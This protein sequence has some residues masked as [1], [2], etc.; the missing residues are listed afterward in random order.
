MRSRRGGMEPE[1]GLDDIFGEAFAAVPALA[2]V[3]LAVD[4]VPTGG[5][6]GAPSLPPGDF[7]AAFAGVP[8][9]ERQQPPAAPPPRRIVGSG[10]WQRTKLGLLFLRS[11][12]ERWQEQRRRQREG[13]AFDSLKRVWNSRIALRLGD[14]LISGPSGG[15]APTCHPNAWTLRGL[16]RVAFSG[17]GSKACGDGGGGVGVTTANAGL[18]RATSTCAGIFSV[19]QAQRVGAIV[20]KMKSREA[21]SIFLSSHYD[22]T[23]R[24]VRF[25]LLQQ[26]VQRHAR[27]LR[28]SA[29][30]KWELVSSERF[31]KLHANAAPRS[32]VVELFAQRMTVSCFLEDSQAWVRQDILCPPRMLQNSGASVVCKAVNAGVPSFSVDGIKDICKGAR[33]V[34]LAEFPDSASSNFRKLH[35]CAPRL[36]ENCLFVPGGCTA[37]LCTRVVEAMGADHPSLLGDV[38][39]AKFVSHLS[40]HYNSLCRALDGVLSEVRIVERR[41]VSDQD[42]ELWQRH[43]RRAVEHTILRKASYARGR[44]ACQDH[45]LDVPAA[46][47][48]RLREL[49]DK[50][51]ALFNGDWRKQEIIHV[52]NGCC[53]SRDETTR[54]MAQVVVEAGILLGHSALPAKSRWGTMTQS[55]A[56]VSLGLLLHGILPRVFR[57]VFS[58]ARAPDQALDPEGEEDFQVGVRR[59]TARVLH[60][61][62][63]PKRFY[64]VFLLSWL[65]E[66]LDWL[67]HRIQHLDE[68]SHCLRDCVSPQRSP[69]R[70]ALRRLSNILI[71]DSLRDTYVCA[72]VDHV[73]AAFEDNQETRVLFM[74]SMWVACLKAAAQVLWRFVLQFEAW[75][76]RLALLADGL[77]TEAEH[78][79][80]A[81]DLYAAP[82]CCL[83][84]W[85]SQRARNLFA[86][87]VALVN[88]REFRALLREWS[89]TGKMCNMHLE[90]DLATIRHASPD[91]LPFAERVCAAGLLAQVRSRHRAHGGTSGA[92][93]RAVLLDEQVPIAAAASSRPSIPT[94]ARGHLAHMH[95]AVRQAKA[96]KGMP[97]T[98]EEANSERRRAC[99]EFALLD[100]QAREQMQQKAQSDARI[101]RAAAERI[102]VGARSKFDASREDFLWGL[103][104]ADSPLDEIVAEGV[105]KDAL[106]IDK[107]GPKG[108]PCEFLSQC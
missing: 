86:D 4:E 56:E 95:A 1:S 31:G 14:S 79:Q 37:H 15:G 40:S 27:Y 5:V 9:A 107:A 84:R 93:T 29:E 68:T 73:D 20:Q 72:I 58:N 18:L 74:R 98:K 85:C 90:R 47:E 36:P 16:I 92:V 65:C 22:A 26:A 94:K 59:K 97:L 106:H 102:G 6:D 7:A 23:P 2:G 50:L 66:P 17:L 60:F 76:F 57:R 13:K 51:I 41:H 42:F 80:V 32:G 46:G 81:R 78:A 77:L 108:N 19:A 49:S 52:E 38:Y 67:L 100:N 61:L 28:L 101:R 99:Q 62:S 88:D 21:T 34:L 45:S 8:R 82:T 69:F 54:C 55:C 83:D 75:P 103:S 53:S 39:S 63:T 30:G 3:Q 87:P 91:T 71:A 24:L 64:P 44:L 104:A 33:F 12:K 89:R 11:Q 48:A 70:N 10:R 35:A 105:I 96:R 43:A 25:G